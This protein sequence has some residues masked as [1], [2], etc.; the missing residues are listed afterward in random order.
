MPMKRR[1][2][3]TAV[4]TFSVVTAFSQSYY[5]KT[6]VIEKPD[7]SGLK[8]ILGK[9]ERDSIESGIKANLEENFS[10]YVQM[11]TAGDEEEARRTMEIQA[12][13]SESNA[14][15]N[16]TGPEIG[17]FARSFY[18]LQTKVLRQNKQFK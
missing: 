11:Q 7:I 9:T 10:K 2:L 13:E 17:S 4:L 6:I 1:I 5:N 18:A 14:Y 12:R 8:D 3:F 16:S 15:D